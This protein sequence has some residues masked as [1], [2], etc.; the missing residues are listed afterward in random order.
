M[1]TSIIKINSNPSSF[2]PKL[3]MFCVTSPNRDGFWRKQ[4]ITSLPHFPAP[5]P[6]GDMNTNEVL[7][8]RPP[9]A[10]DM[11]FFRKNMGL[12]TSGVF[13]RLTHINPLKNEPHEPEPWHFKLLHKLIILRL[14][15][16]FFSNACSFNDFL[17]R[18]SLSPIQRHENVHRKIL[19]PTII[20]GSKLISK[21]DKMIML[22]FHQRHKNPQE[23]QVES[24]WEGAL[25]SAFAAGISGS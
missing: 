21:D 22:T 14:W 6:L 20:G 18:T 11:G 25:P 1:E 15:W 4:H 17:P 3:A 13:I 16:W 24:T 10:C 2:L 5:L 7:G 19:F 12:Q 8:S 9:G 23:K